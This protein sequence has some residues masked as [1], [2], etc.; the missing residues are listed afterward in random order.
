M[1][2]NK[3]EFTVD[4]FLVLCPR[5]CFVRLADIDAPE[6][7]QGHGVEARDFL[8]KWVCGRRVRV[9][10]GRADR[11]GRLLGTLW[12]GGENINERL[13]RAGHAWRYRYAKKTG[14]IAVAEKQAREHR[15]GLWSSNSATEPFAYRSNKEKKIR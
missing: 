12:V 4:L 8:G 11:Y 5:F 15:L 13:V 6:L 10:W 1:S 2:Q 7:S 14:L 3:L 9:E